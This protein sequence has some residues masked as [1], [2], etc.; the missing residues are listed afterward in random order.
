MVFQSKSNLNISKSKDGNY[1][2]IEMYDIIT[3]SHWPRSI[4]FNINLQVNS[5]YF[6]LIKEVLGGATFKSYFI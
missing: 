3:G 6:K 4:I 2:V 1:Y 5:K